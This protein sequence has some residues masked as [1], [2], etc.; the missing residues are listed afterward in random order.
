MCRQAED[1][2]ED[3]KVKKTAASASEEASSMM[4]MVV[5]E[6]KERKKDGRAI[7]RASEIETKKIESESDNKETIEESS[8]DN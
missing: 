7:A 8:V 2:D 4:L 1:R 5:R 3:V 6:G